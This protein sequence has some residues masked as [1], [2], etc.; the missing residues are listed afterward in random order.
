MKVAIVGGGGFRV[1]LVYDALLAR[2]GALGVEQ[3]ALHDVD[4]GRLRRIGAVLRGIDREREASL[5][6]LA[7]TDLAA[8]VEGADFVFCAIRPG[9][10]EGRV[11]DE[12]VPLAEGILGQETTGPGG[13]AFALRTVPAMVRIAE[14]V[15]VRAPR[16]RFVN[17]TNP[18]GLVTEAV[19]PVLGERAIGVCDSSSGLCRRVARALGRRPEE[20]WFDYFGL[21]HL[22]WLRAVRDDERDLLPDLIADEARLA[23]F[24][25]G[26]L[27]GAEWLQT[28]GMI[29]NEY[30][31][32]HY[33]AAETAAATRAAPEVRAEFL[34]RQ[35]AAFYAGDGGGAGPEAALA[36][37]RA[38]RRDR[39]GAYFAEVRAA[40]GGAAV[41]EAAAPHEA[42][43]AGGYEVEA[44]AIVEAVSRGEPR[45]LIVDTANR[46]SLPFLDE[47]AV[48]EVPAL[49]GRTGVV[50]FAVGD[51]PRHARILVESVKEVERL[52]IRAAIERSRR[53]AIEAI[54]LHPLVRSARAAERIFDAYRA[55]L[56]DLAD[57][58]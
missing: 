53:L 4:A 6:V 29:P 38:A 14:A 8:A 58:R 21:N 48:V 20:L 23:T 18:A 41:G 25:E 24:E 19:Q 3:V 42:D 10:L 55:R 50:P 46:G 7:T 35:Q 5:P 28:L 9:G 49:V 51:V 44:L 16:A 2:S 33:F 57:M 34:L 27:F 31:A 22:G 43:P 39:E 56:P 12:R 13:I 26:R 54:A 52:T 36:A 1:P 32:Y 11:A 17:L 40:T 30:L 15:A 45:V 37:W 47:R